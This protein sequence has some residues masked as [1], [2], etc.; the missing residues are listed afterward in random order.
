MVRAPGHWRQPALVLLR[1]APL[2][3]AVVLLRVAPLLRAVVFLRVAL[4]ASALW[5]VFLVSVPAKK[6]QG[7]PWKDFMIMGLLN[8]AIPFSLLVWGQ[9][10]ISSSL[11][12]IINATTPFFTV[13]IAHCLL[14]DER[15][16]KAKIA[17]TSA[18]FFG[19][20]ILMGPGVLAGADVGLAG[21]LA[22]G[23]FCFLGTG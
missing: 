3:R 6:R 5:C 10:Q 18:G 16:S 23:L 1:V 14:A 9:T 15:M 22:G 12:S 8:N 20:V 2:L 4:G 17:G 13:V 21:Q 11:A 19:I 7:L